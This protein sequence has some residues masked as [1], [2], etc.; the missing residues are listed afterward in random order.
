MSE[1]TTN[2]V[3]FCRDLRDNGFLIGPTEQVDALRALEAI[4][5]DNSESFRLSLRT[6][7]CSSKNDQ[8]IFD[9]LYSKFWLGQKGQLK[10]QDAACV[11]KNPAKMT[12]LLSSWTAVR[13]SNAKPEAGYSPMETFTIKQFDD[14]PERDLLE[15]SQLVRAMARLLSTRP[16]RRF[17]ASRKHHLFDFRKTLRLSLRNGE[18]LDLAYRER[19]PRPLKLVLLC[20]VS[21]SMESY[22]RFLLTFIY[23]LQQSYRGVE[24]F[25]FSTALRRV[26]SL[27]KAESVANA[28]RNVSEAVPEWSGGTRIGECLQTFVLDH[29]KLLTRD[30]VVLI[31]SDGW[32]VGDLDVLEDSMEEISKQAH[33]TIWLNPLQDGAEFEP[34]CAGMAAA[35]PYLDALLPAHDLQKLYDTLRLC[36]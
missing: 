4:P 33:R 11:K 25:V 21:G 12:T 22:T 36:G 18:V 13:D 2:V 7:L 17:R 1:L 3:K 8:A 34:S 15:M 5:L 31:L 26:T 28:L 30:T 19:A 10:F 14:L 32:D 29:R 23:A 16:G 24:T 20:D 35:V 27:M 9:Q 6:I